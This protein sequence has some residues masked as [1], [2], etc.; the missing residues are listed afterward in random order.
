[1]LLFVFSLNFDSRKEHEWLQQE[2]HRVRVESHEYMSY[3]EKKTSK[4]QTTIITLSDHNKNEIKN[5]QL[6][7]Q[8]MEEEF[9][10]KKR[11]LENMLLEKQNM[12]KKTTEELGELQE[13]KNLQTEQLTKIKEL[14][15]E[16]MQ[17]RSKHSETISQLK[18]QFLQEKKDFQNDAENRINTLEKKA[19][20]EAIQCLTEHTNRIKLENRHLRKELL[21]LIQQT[22]A[23]QAHQKELEEQRKQLLREQQYANDLK[24]LRKTRQHKVMKTFELSDRENTDLSGINDTLDISKD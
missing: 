24:Q 1:M 4:R 7:K 13:Y 6:Q 20:K 3:M 11:I 21:E 18:A 8:I 2:A 5:L 19:N 16:L 9:D 22:R 14:E 10:E 23:Y 15:K 17:Y 12:L